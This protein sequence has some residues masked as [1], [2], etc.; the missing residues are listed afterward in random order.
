MHWYIFGRLGRKIAVNLN[1]NKSVPRSSY[2]HYVY[3]SIIGFIIFV[4]HTYI[5]TEISNSATATAT[6]TAVCPGFDSFHFV[7]CL[8]SRIKEVSFLFRDV[9]YYSLF[10]IYYLLYIYILAFLP[11]LVL[12]YL[13]YTESSFFLLLQIIINYYLIVLSMYFILN[14]MTILQVNDSIWDERMCY[15]LVDGIQ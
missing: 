6:H 15:Q 7:I 3:I 11:I 13:F 9:I 2:I 4:V 12:K 14:L 8:I 5:S 10:N 1:N